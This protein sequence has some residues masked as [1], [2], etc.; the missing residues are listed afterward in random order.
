MCATVNTK[1]EQSCIVS[2]IA[3][4]VLWKQVPLNRTKSR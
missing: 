3:L 2:C 4:M 1:T